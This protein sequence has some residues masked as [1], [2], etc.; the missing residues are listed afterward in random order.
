MT[1]NN[2]LYIFCGIP[3]SGKSTLTKALA[4]R[5]GFHRI[6]LD[7]IK[8]EMYG[9]AIE[10]KNLTQ[11]DWDKIYQEMYDRIEQSLRAGHT[12]VRDTG[13]FTKNERN[14]VRH[15]GNKAGVEVMT[16][17]VNTPDE[18]ARQRLAHNRITKTRF[19]ITDKEFEEALSEMEA[20]YNSEAHIIFDWRTSADYWIKAHID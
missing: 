19:D 20:P 15:I 1:K 16:V 2:K 8:F 14:L 7:E 10:D 17:F 11:A 6:D 3:F 18:V 5:K 4:R 12:V 13:N 9:N